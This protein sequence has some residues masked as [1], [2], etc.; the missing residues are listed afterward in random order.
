[1]F[2]LKTRKEGDIYYLY[3]MQYIQYIHLVLDLIYLI[4]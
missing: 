1:M 4:A 3:I 2:Y